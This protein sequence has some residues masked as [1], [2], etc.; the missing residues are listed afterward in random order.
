MFYCQ[1]ERTQLNV[2]SVKIINTSNE[3]LC[4]YIYTYIENIT[5]LQYLKQNETE[6]A[7]I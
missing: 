6:Y 3:N 4:I 1:I 5:S 2:F 7:L